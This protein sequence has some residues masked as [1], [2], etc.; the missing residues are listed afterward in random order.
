MTNEA[1]ER[2]AFET[3]LRREYPLSWALMTAHETALMRDAWKGA[4][5]AAPA[6]HAPVAWVTGLQWKPRQTEQVVKLTRETQPEYGYTVP[7]YAAAPTAAQPTDGVAGAAVTRPCSVTRPSDARLRL[8]DELHELLADE[9]LSDDKLRAASEGLLPR[10]HDWLRGIPAGVPAS[11]AMDA[12]QANGLAWAVSRWQ[13]EVS[14]RPLVNV[15]RRTLDDTWRQ[16]VRYFGGDPDNLL[17]PAHDALA[18]GVKACESFDACE[19]GSPLWCMKHGCE[20]ATAS[21]VPVDRAI[22]FTQQD[23]SKPVKGVAL[24]S[25]V[26]LPAA[27]PFSEAKATI[28]ALPERDVRALAIAQFIQLQTHEKYGNT[29]QNLNA[30]YRA[31][32]AAAGVREVPHG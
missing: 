13:A 23:G 19:H 22:E 11:D 3:W 18:A 9:N 28:M 16:V 8:A 4:R 29:M 26:A 5:A 20:K 27:T 31:E 12:H 25:G 10:L 24:A 30:A 14:Q 21:G 7:L 15:H 1:S 2:E 32:Q 6:V 17:G